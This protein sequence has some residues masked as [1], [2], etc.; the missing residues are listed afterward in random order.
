VHLRLLTTDR[1]DEGYEDAW[2]PVVFKSDPRLTQFIRSIQHSGMVPSEA[3]PALRALID[4]ATRWK[5]AWLPDM[6]CLGVAAVVSWVLLPQLEVTGV[7]RFGRDTAGAGG[8]LASWWYWA[9]CLTVVRF[10][11]LR[12][13]W[14]LGLWFHC[15][16]QLSRLPLQLRAGHPDG[17]AGLGFLE[18]V[19]GHFLPLVLAIS[20]EL[21]ASFA[22]DIAAGAMALEDVYPAIFAIVL[23]DG[24]LF[25]GPLFVF[26][27]KLWACRVNG[28]VDYMEFAERYV[29]DFEA[30][31]LRPDA[32]PD[33]AP[34]GSSDIQSLADLGSSVERVRDMRVVPVSTRLLMQIAVTALLPMLPLALFKYPIADLAREVFS[35]LVGL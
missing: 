27:P 9:V 10:L 3:Q 33:E 6:A 31:W 13:V 25:I 5:N 19:H 30:K 34:L 16:W 32:R 15:L 17:V 4:R 12:W 26:A 14:R 24:L 20:V 23:V 21:A 1:R 8:T 29:A 22:A 28:V 2:V 7:V 35:R 18:V 11:L